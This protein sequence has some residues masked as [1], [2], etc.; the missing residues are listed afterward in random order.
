MG[1]FSRIGTYIE[2]RQRKAAVQNARDKEYRETLERERH[3]ARMQGARNLAIREE[4]TRTKQKL[5]DLRSGKS[6]GGWGD[7]R[8]MAVGMSDNLNQSYGFGTGKGKGSDFGKIDM[9]FGKGFGDTD[10]G[11]GGP[12]KHKPHKKHSSHK[13]SGG[14]GTTII[15]RK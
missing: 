1:M 7:L 3:D 2:N 9:G 15:I 12:A 6:S 4:R 11:F 8:N 10:F 13:K 14:R 5:K